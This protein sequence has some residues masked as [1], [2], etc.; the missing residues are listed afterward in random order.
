M[1]VSV[2]LD[3]DMRQ[4]IQALAESKQRSAHWI[5]REAIR[6]YVEK[7]EAR[8]R[9]D[10]HTLASWQ[11]YQETGCT[12][13]AKRFLPGWRA[14]AR[15][16]RRMLRLATPRITDTAIADLSRLRRFLVDKNPRAA[17][18]AFATIRE[19]LVLITETPSA[20]RPV[21]TLEPFRE[22]LIPFGDG[23][24]I[25]RYGMMLRPTPSMWWPFAIR[26]KRICLRDW[27]RP[28]D[29]SSGFLRI[30]FRALT[31]LAAPA[32]AS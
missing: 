25:A 12:L 27:V 30:D 9:F 2:K 21:P 17:Q 14:G 4:R 24:Y 11:H 23:G 1:A 28:G 31:P 29:L 8:R 20:G 16:R 3:D 5:M 15:M 32:A 13:P 6:G 10:E 19:R 26:K 18:R 22:I 7:E